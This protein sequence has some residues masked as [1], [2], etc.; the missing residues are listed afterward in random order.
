MSGARVFPIL[1]DTYRA[2]HRDRL[3]S[4]PWGL[5]SPHEAQA[6]QNHNQTLERLA[7]RGGL[8]ARE[9]MAV[10]SGDSWSAWGDV[11]AEEAERQ[12]GEL[13]AV[14]AGSRT[15][16]AASRPIVSLRKFAK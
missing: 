15:A 4:I 11:S 9:A 16:T 2:R 1:R 8:S 13:V 7:Q 3:R 10:L 6:K 5:I 14:A 12:L